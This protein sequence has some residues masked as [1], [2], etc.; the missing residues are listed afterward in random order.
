MR[1]KDF[2]IV[3]DAHHYDTIK[4]EQ[5]KNLIFYSLILKH[6]NLQ[7]EHVYKF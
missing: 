2:L 1:I 4:D 5:N 6:W 7:Y 3:V